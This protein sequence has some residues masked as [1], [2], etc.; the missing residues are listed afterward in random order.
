[1]NDGGGNTWLDR[2][3]HD[4]RGPLAPLQTAT[5]LLQREDLDPARRA[6]LLAMLERQA[7]RLARM[8]DEL[9]DW[10]RIGRG[11]L[12]GTRQ[13]SELALLL[14]HALV[15]SGL[16]GTPVEDDGVAAGVR[17]DAQRMTQVLRTLLDYSLARDGVA[18]AL[19]LRRDDSRSSLE[20]TLSG[21]P[22]ADTEVA[23]L[24]DQPQ[25][26]PFDEG[27][28]LRLPLAREIVR[29]HGGELSA[30]VAGGRLVLR[31]ELPL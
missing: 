18:P 14:D 10:R 13:E 6:E 17:V 2:L 15:A 24:F 26:D 16:A 30:T 28:G 1:M 31:C 12:L 29:A 23:T 19:A 3:A 9:D 11:N 5:Y 27:L 8:L 25:A 22:P 20:L 4:L 7:Q 21:P